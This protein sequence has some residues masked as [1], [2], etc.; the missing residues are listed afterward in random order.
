MT[1]KPPKPA[2]RG[3]KP[4]KPKVVTFQPP[5]TT[6]FVSFTSNITRRYDDLYRFRAD[7]FAMVPDVQTYPNAGQ[8]MDVLIGSATIRNK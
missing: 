4:I 1:D 7:A 6:G 5:W 8:S 3:P 2:K